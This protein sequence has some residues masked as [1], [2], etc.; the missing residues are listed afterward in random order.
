MDRKTEII[1]AALELASENGLGTVSMQ[2]IAEKIGITKAS[3]YN[4]F[5]SRDQIVE[6]MY[7][8]IR[9]ASKQRAGIGAVD[10]DQLTEGRSLSDILNSAVENYRKIITDPQMHL[11]YRVIMSERSINRTA[12]EIMVEE[13]RTMINASKMLFYA[14]QVKRIA[15]FQNADTAAVSFA[16]TIHALLD[17]ECDCEH[18]GREKNEKL[19]QD[20]IAEFCRI[21]Q[22]KGDE[23]HEE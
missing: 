11:F 7:A 21:Y 10:Y 9:E 1:H 22:A 4:H 14:L 5:S 16:M 23:K 19:L 12:A 18:S 8:S 20:F 3:L 17:Y 6:A 15:N 2:Q 13:T